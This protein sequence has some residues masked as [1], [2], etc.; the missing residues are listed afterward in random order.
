MTATQNA[1]DQLCLALYVRDG[2]NAHSQDEDRYHWALL[3][4]PSQSNRALRFHARDYFTDS[5]QTHWIYEEIH[6]SARG[7]PKLLSQTY[8]GYI[9][10]NERL[11]GI[12]REAPIMQEKGWN[13]ESW[14]DEAMAMVWEDGVLEAGRLKDLKSLK[15]D[16]LVAADAEILRREIK[17]KARL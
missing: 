12:L 13:C 15:R 6:V 17:S 14:I 16:A 2:V 5:D 10:D 4:V 7:T 1:K 8:I 11:F 3:A 9:S